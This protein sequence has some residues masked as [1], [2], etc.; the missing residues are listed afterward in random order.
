MSNWVIT[1]PVLSTIHIPSPEA[2]DLMMAT[3]ASA[4]DDCGYLN[5]VR[6]EEIDRESKDWLEPIADWAYRKYKTEWVRFD[7]DGDI[8]PEL[9]NYE[10]KWT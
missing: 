7:P 5:F 10:E 9:P 8:I 4:C 1:I 3:Q 6:L 2:M